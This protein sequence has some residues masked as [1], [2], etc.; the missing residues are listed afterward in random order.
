MTN[1]ISMYRFI[2]AVLII[3]IIT[4]ACSVAVST[5]K[6][7]CWVSPMVFKLINLSYTS[8]SFS[9]TRLIHML[10]LTSS[11]DNCS[12]HDYNGPW[13]VSVDCNMNVYSTVRKKRACE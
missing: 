2:C 3:I 4:V 1:F 7:F 11:N 9:V 13:L 12:P 6:A 8:L 5:K 10:V